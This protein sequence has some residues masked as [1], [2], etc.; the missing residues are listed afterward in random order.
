MTLR[1]GVVLRPSRD[2]DW[3]QGFEVAQRAV[4]HNV[5]AKMSIVL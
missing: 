3:V 4:S 1:T 5:R 2:A